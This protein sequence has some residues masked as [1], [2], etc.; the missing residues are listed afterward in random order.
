VRVTA[1]LA[2]LAL[3]GAMALSGCGADRPSG[4]EDPS[5]ASSARNQPDSTA[6]ARS[7]A[8]EV[9]VRWPAQQDRYG[10]YKGNVRGFT[11]Y[12][13]SV[14]GYSLLAVGL[15]EGE[16]RLVTSGLKAVTFAAEARPGQPQH[17]NFENLAVTLA[18]ELAERRLRSDPRYRRVRPAWVR[19]LRSVPLSRLPD[20]VFYGN[21]HLVEAVYVLELEKTGL[22]SN[23]PLAIVGG[24]RARAVA[25]AKDLVN[26][27]LV[28]LMNA[29][30]VRSRGE[31]TLLLSDPPGNPLS[32]HGLSFG[33]YARA[34]SLLGRRATRPARELLERVANA[35]WQ[36]TA[37]DGDL[38]YSGRNQ[39]Q[40]FGPGL[41]AYGA[42]MT[43]D[44]PGSDPA[45]DQ[46]L[47][48]LARRAIVR[49]R[50]AHGGGRYGLYIT[51]S[52]K[53]G[54]GPSALSG[55]DSS[56]GVAS[57]TGLTMMALN[58]ALERSDRKAD[59]PR[60]A[61]RLAGDRDGASL[62]GTGPSRHTTVRH[63]DLWYAVK[64]GPETYRLADLRFDFGLAALKRR[65]ADGSWTDVIPIKPYTDAQP[66]SAGPILD[67]DG[68]RALPYA[69]A[70]RVGP[71]GQVIVTGGWRTPDG[72][73]VRTGVRFRYEPSGCGLR[74]SWPALEGDSFE[75]SAFL[76][77]G[78]TRPTATG[79]SLRSSDQTLRF[80][81]RARTF[82][83]E[84]YAS[85]SDAA[86]TRAYL[87]W[88]EAPRET[89]ERVTICPP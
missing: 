57:F 75:Y 51:P 7:L 78:R 16:Q 38:G 34:I 85:A 72:A 46:R 35:S 40:V 80:A 9:A 39:E 59:H 37:P 45:H 44:L 81:P 43:A 21:H 54:A 79:G 63:G 89:R 69:D 20:L 74:V 3:A 77:R 19:F 10:R 22:R 48:A 14:L 70:F 52:L 1:A 4:G 11:R 62:V 65:Q 31:R 83:D 71:R 50:D 84:G 13:E 18:F 25:L 61:S 36:L 28:A 29:T 64:A 56:A 15:R 49:L 67:P 17:S 32:Y 33:M 23:D 55:L 26:R 30:T 5:A 24:D 86:L 87:R 88:D 82:Y 73:P 66:D 8:R 42:R 27:R 58:W 53:R 76:R 60:A 68:V 12:G 41:T 2:A 47:E 6:M